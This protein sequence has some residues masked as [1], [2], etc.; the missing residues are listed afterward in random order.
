ML[1]KVHGVEG[2][3]VLYRGRYNALKC[4][5]EEDT[6]STNAMF[7]ILLIL[8]CLAAFGRSGATLILTIGWYLA[9]VASMKIARKDKQASAETGKTT[10][11]N[12]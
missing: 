5:T 12:E 11:D 7:V 6:M 9:P 10:I 8:V 1:R 3:L 4:H 2:I